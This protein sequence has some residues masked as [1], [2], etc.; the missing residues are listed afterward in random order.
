MKK[1]LI[2]V[3]ALTILAAG[4]IL[5]IAIRNGL[6]TPEQV[7]SV[8]AKG[9]CALVGL[10]LAMVATL[11]LSYRGK[12]ISRVRGFVTC[13]PLTRK[14]R[15]RNRGLWITSLVILATLTAALA[16]YLVANRFAPDT[17]TWVVWSAVVGYIVC[18]PFRRSAELDPIGPS[19]TMQEM[20]RETA[21]G[22]THFVIE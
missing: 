2:W 3:T 14:E 4:A 18:I 20:V 5:V 10:A 22:P 17:I 6:F 16:I 21:E 7:E 1:M 12:R 8:L 19:Q 11:P 13:G 9:F 15:R